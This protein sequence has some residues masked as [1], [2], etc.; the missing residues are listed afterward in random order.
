MR[1]DSAGVGEGAPAAVCE[2]RSATAW[3]WIREGE[4]D[5]NRYWEKDLPMERRR[6]R[7][8]LGGAAGR[9]AAHCSHDASLA[10][11]SGIREGQR[12]GH[13]DHRRELGGCGGAWRR[14]RSMAAVEVLVAAGVGEARREFFPF[15]NGGGGIWET[16]EERR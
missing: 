8:P 15:A 2:T 3:C 4:E 13:Q 9:K 1:W 12:A 10:A 6:L 5:G 11:G 16:R 7:E 14:R